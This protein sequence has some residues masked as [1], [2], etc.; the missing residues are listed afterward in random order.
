MSHHLAHT[1]RTPNL[2]SRVIANHGNFVDMQNDCKNNLSSLP[3]NVTK[4]LQSVSQVVTSR[5]KVSQLSQR[6]ASFTI[7]K[8]SSMHSANP[9]S[10]STIHVRATGRISL[11]FPVAKPTAH[12]STPRDWASVTRAAW[13]GSWFVVR[14]AMT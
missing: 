6:E 12:A 9:I 13:D 8:Y 1:S 3:V 11:L 4:E 7:S 5:A 10:L 2:Q 14:K